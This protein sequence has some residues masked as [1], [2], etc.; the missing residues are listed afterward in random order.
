MNA[1]FCAEVIV[2]I[3]DLSQ[4]LRVKQKTHCICSEFCACNNDS[5]LTD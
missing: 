3:M 4:Q 5:E 2:L 1:V